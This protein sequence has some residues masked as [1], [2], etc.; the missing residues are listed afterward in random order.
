MKNFS[1]IKEAITDYRKGKAIIIVDDPMREN[2]GDIVYSAEKITPAKI[3]FMAKEGRGLICVCLEGKRLDELDIQPMVANGVEVQEASFTVSV[4]AKK[5]ITTGI[6]A[7]DR[8]TT[9]K[10][11]INSKTKPDDII[12]PGHIFPLRYKEGGVLVRA[13][14]TEASVDIA[15]IS[16][17]Y[18]AS[19]ICEIMNED[20][21][22][23]R[24]P[25]LIKFAQKYK[26]KIITI[27]QIIEY[28]RKTEK[29]IEKI[30]TTDFPTRYGNFVLHL[31]QDKI[32]KE[33]HIALVKG[34]VRNK[35]NVLTRVHSS[36]LTGDTFH[37]L[38]CDCGDQL[39]K[40]IQII[41]KEKVG[42]LL[43]M[44]QEGRGIG[45]TNK[46]KA[47]QLQDNGYD[48]V[49][50]NLKLGFK[51]DLRDYGIGA[52]ILSDLGLSTIKLLTNN[53]KKIVGLEGYGLKIVE[54][55]PIQITPKSKIAKKYLKT[56]EKKLGHL[57]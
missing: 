18:P 56:K 10:V 54:R 48:T 36:C 35:K 33:N 14:H 38:R 1:D 30:V 13:G 31:Y 5:G 32:K 19:V 15:K 41:Q 8:A 28:R 40:S 9:V 29:L 53:P 3:N 7:H 23:A 24:L 57:L 2:E 27:A 37:S 25:Q 52:Q 43:Y 34:E 16:G 46:L 44:H 39:E 42:V 4:D 55:I 17:L 47:Y 49:E 45:L 50:A 12:K 26:L 51:P 11:L 20:G 22:M 6:S 21:T